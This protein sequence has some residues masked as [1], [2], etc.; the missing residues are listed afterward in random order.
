[1]SCSDNNYPT[2]LFPRGALEMYT[3]KNMGWDVSPEEVL[4]I[5]FLEPLFSFILPSLMSPNTFLTLARFR[6]PRGCCPSAAAARETTA[7]GFAPK[8]ATRLNA[9]RPS[10]CQSARLVG[11]RHLPPPALCFL[12]RP[13]IIPIPFNSQGSETV[14]WKVQSEAKCFRGTFC[15]M[16]MFLY[17]CCFVALFVC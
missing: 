1:M 8:S 11:R 7:R 14:D 9:L 16:D 12:N 17:I 2:Q 6:K 10:L 3:A 4:P 13:Q 15:S 5:T